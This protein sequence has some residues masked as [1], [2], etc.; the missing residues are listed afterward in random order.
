M[1]RRVPE[2]PEEGDLDEA[3][4]VAP[5]TLVPTVE[6]RAA[7]RVQLETPAPL[8]DAGAHVRRADMAE[9]M[10]VAL[11]QTWDRSAPAPRAAPAPR[12]RSEPPSFRV[13]RRE[14]RAAR[15]PRSRPATTHQI[16]VYRGDLLAEV[17]RDSGVR[18]EAEPAERFAPLAAHVGERCAAD[19]L[20]F[21]ETEWEVRA[22][23][24][25]NLAVHVVRVLRAFVESVFAAHRRRAPQRSA[26]PRARAID[27]AIAA[28]VEENVEDEEE[29]VRPEIAF[30]VGQDRYAAL[31]DRYS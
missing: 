21:I 22:A 10:E 11:Q 15:H 2:I 25:D 20:E 1:R 5:G 23:A 3:L 19:F 14:A 12:R 16:L 18:L 24:V 17:L 26:G 30:E 7:P 8:R 4:F 13:G 31:R 27:V 6:P 29:T 9:N 28:V